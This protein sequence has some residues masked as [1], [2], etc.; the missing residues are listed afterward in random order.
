MKIIELTEEEFRNYSA[1]HSRRNHLQ[2]IEYSN[3]K[4]ED[5]YE[6]L[7]LGLI[8][9][10]DNIIAGSLILSKK[11]NN[12]NKYAYAPWGYLIDYSNKDLLS[13]FTTKLKEYLKK[14]D[15]V[16]LQTNPNIRF[17]VYDK[18]LNIIDGNANNINILKS[19]GYNFTGY[20]DDFSKYNIYLKG[21]DSLNAIYNKFSRN[22]KRDIDFCSKAYITVHKGSLEDFDLFYNLVKNTSNKSMEFYRKLFSYFNTDYNRFEIFFSKLNPENYINNYKYLLKQEQEKNEKIASKL[23]NS[24]NGGSIKLV[25]EKMKSDKIIEKYK[26]EIVRATNVYK[27]FPDGLIIGTCG[28]IRN[29]KSIYFIVDGYNNQLNYIHSIPTIKWEII[30]IYHSVNYKEFY[31]G[32]VHSDFNNI[33]YK[34]LLQNKL[35]MGG[36]I[37]EY[38]G[39][40]N[41]VINKYLYTIYSNFLNI[42]NNNKK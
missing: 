38:P 20:K 26:K 19:C 29:N 36:E 8:D 2:T 27:V 3:M 25:N 6:S 33:N 24:D 22:I 35:G 42:G 17:K 34:G 11:I 15:F 16:Y 31:L 10:N 14:K 40:F 41:L 4:K 21:E 7:F 13:I 5:N 18:K 1:V 23:K 32:P 9:D 39:N 28:I 37:I 12:K 30:K